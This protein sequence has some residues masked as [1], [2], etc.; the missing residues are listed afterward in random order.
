MRFADFLIFDEAARAVFTDLDDQRAFRCYLERLEE[1]ARRYP[2][3]FLAEAAASRKGV[4]FRQKA[5]DDTEHAVF[6]G[7]LA[8]RLPTKPAKGDYGNFLRRGIL[9]QGQVL[10]DMKWGEWEVTKA[11][12]ELGG[13]DPAAVTN[14]KTTPAQRMALLGQVNWASVTLPRLKTALGGSLRVPDD[15]KRQFAIEKLKRIKDAVEKGTPLNA[16]DGKLLNIWRTLE[17][18]LGNDILP[19]GPKSDVGLTRLPMSPVDRKRF[20][21]T[22]TGTNESVAPRQPLRLSPQSVYDY[23]TQRYNVEIINDEEA[24]DL[25]LTRILQDL[26]NNNAFIPSSP[27]GSEADAKRWRDG[28]ARSWGGF[29]GPGRFYDPRNAPGFAQ[30]LTGM[31]TKGFQMRTNPSGRR[32]PTGYPEPEAFQRQGD[33][34]GIRYSIDT[35]SQ[36]LPSVEINA[37]Y[38]SGTVQANTAVQQEL[39]KPA[40]DAVNWLR[41]KGWI[42]DTAKA[43]DIVQQVVVMLSRTGACGDWRNNLGFRRATASMLARRFASQGWPSA[44]KER[45]GRLDTGQ[46]ESGD[47]QTTSSNRQGREDAFSRV[48]GGVARARQAVQRVIASLMGIDTSKLGGEDG[49]KFTDAIDSLSDP[50]HAARAIET[51]DRL[52]ARHAAELPQV[53]QAMDRIHRHLEPLMAKMRVGADE[54]IP[55]RQGRT[56]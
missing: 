16:E 32:V 13:V 35:P 42:A 20:Y 30:W 50:K 25:Y 36:E 14:P 5:L 10:G 34:P 39:L 24:K 53:K 29:L 40:R 6:A 11:V 41:T 43:D 9:Q 1:T 7:R 19:A 31:T 49:A 55:G 2:G 44:T 15:W 18:Q 38:R 48:Q 37:F 17:V 54:D 26:K 28:V 45:T 4:A 27:Q 8:D 46:D 22:L 51:L 12:L 21:R 23:L 47:L 56:E 3:T 33:V 52:A